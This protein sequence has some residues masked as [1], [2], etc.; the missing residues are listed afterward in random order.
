MSRLSIELTEQ[1]HRQIKTMASLRGQTIKQYVVERILPA[2][3]VS[4]DEMAAMRALKELLSKRIERA[5]S[6]K[7]SGKTIEQVTADYLKN[8]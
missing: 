5:D 6:G 8:K 1:E 4:D 2:E 3:E 7:G